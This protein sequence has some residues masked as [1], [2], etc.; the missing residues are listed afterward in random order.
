MIVRTRFAPS[1]TGYLHLGGVRTALYCWLHAKKTGGKFILRIEDTD[2][3]RSTVQATENILASL[4]WLGL[5]W[6]EGPFYQMQHLPRYYEVAQTLIN[7]GHAYYCYCSKEH[8]EELH[9]QQLANKQKPKYD[10][11][12]RALPLKQPRADQAYVV[13][14]RNPDSGA[15]HFIDLI[16]GEITI[17][18]VELDDVILIRSDGVPTYNFSVVVD[19]IDMQITHVLRGEDHI[20][21]TPRQINI[22]QALQTKSPQYAHVP[23][24]LTESGERLS[25]RH[26]ALSVLQYRRDGFLK[27][28]L[29]N[30]LVRL[31]WSHGDQEIFSIEEMQQLFDIEHINKAAARMNYDKLIWLNQHYLKTLPAEYLAEELA[32]QF[33]ELKIAIDDQAPPLSEIIVAQR[34]RVTTMQEL[35]LRSRCFVTEFEQIDPEA[36]TKH[37]SAQILPPLRDTMQVLQDL[38]DSATGGWGDKE[39]IHQIIINQAEKLGLK[40]G[41]LAQP[42]RVAVSGSS[43]SPPID[44]TLRLIG[45]KRAIARLANA[46][47]WIENN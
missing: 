47:K 22:Y 34:E 23:M 4:R 33:T 20:G 40:L 8:L 39:A 21:N 29:L 5:T 35:A 17:N 30:Y 9:Q 19:D 12:C 24:I 7:N 45:K 13:R 32:W 15:V 28:A 27:E 2:R 18:N 16:R 6:D 44:I 25:K 3:E 36:A 38:P 43:V 11:H 46:I 42:I 1:P 14:F 37:L 31:G 41:K 26:G 10:G